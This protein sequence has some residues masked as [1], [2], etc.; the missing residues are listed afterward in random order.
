MAKTEPATLRRPIQAMTWRLRIG[1][2][3]TSAQFRST[4][5]ANLALGAGAAMTFAGIAYLV[6]TVAEARRR[7]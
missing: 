1:Q 3:R 2:F 6:R 4:A 7:R 5:L